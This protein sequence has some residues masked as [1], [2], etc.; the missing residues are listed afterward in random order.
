MQSSLEAVK[1][2]SAWCGTIRCG[3]VDILMCM[4]EKKMGWGMARMMQGKARSEWS[5]V[6]WD[7]V[8]KG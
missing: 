3:T 7:G 2:T 5:G 6:E 8:R 4:E 1:V